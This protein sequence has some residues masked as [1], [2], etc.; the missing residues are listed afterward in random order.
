VTS[1]PLEAG[2]VGRFVNPITDICW[3]CIF[4]ITIAGRPVTRG[5]DTPNPHQLICWCPK[6]PLPAV[7]G[8]PISF[9]EPVRLIDITRTPYCMVNLGGLQIGPP[10]RS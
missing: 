2:C 1:N 4:P 9:W 8:I 10:N 5:E 7:P 6:P 3:R